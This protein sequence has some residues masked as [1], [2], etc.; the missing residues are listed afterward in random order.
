L[1]CDLAGSTA[2]SARLDPEDLRGI[3]VAY[4]RCCTECIECNGVRFCPWSRAAAIK[5]G[6]RMTTNPKAGNATLFASPRTGDAAWTNLFAATTVAQGQWRFQQRDI[7]C[8]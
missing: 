2:L 3:I 1:F 6:N 5:R 7:N 8:W 4:Q